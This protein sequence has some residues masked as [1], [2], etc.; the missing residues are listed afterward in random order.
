MAAAAG[1]IS[2][3]GRVRLID[4]DAENG[5]LLDFIA[6]HDSAIQY[7]IVHK[8]MTILED[9]FFEYFEAQKT[10]YDLDKVVEQLEDC[11]ADTTESE[12]GIAASWAYKGAIEIVKAGG[13]NE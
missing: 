2:T 12:T 5:K 6:E 10:A 3:E 4:A 13:V 9:I 7:A 8:D 11:I 1:V